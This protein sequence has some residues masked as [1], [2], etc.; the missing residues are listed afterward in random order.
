MTQQ[1]LKS[2]SV[3]LLIFLS[4][5]PVFVQE[6]KSTTA[7]EASNQ[8]MIISGQWFLSY[9]IENENKN[10]NN[11]FRLKRGYVTFRK[12]LNPNLLVRVTQDVTVDREGDGEGD[13]E[14]RLKYGFL[15]YTRDKLSL[16]TRPYI[17]FGVVQ[18]PWIDFEQEIN[19]Y[20]VQ[21][22]MFLERNKIL[23]SADYGLTL[24]AQIGDELKSSN[25]T[26]PGKSG[27]GQFG[28]F[29]LGL[30]NGGGY[31]A[32]EKNANK[33]VQARISLRLLPHTL[34][35]LQLSWTGALGKGNTVAAPNFSANALFFSLEQTHFIFTCMYYSG[36]GNIDGTAVAGNGKSMAPKGFSIF[37]EASLFFPELKLF[38]RLDE[39]KDA[40][41]ELTPDHR[42]YITGIAYKFFKNSRIII[43]YDYL[44]LNNPRKKGETGFELALEF[45]Y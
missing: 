17:D 8:D 35:G 29:A 38:L 33:L 20:R 36:K 41:N 15:R 28:S 9:D 4:A 34:P 11:E 6:K 39:F 7:S 25:S 1:N 27:Q 14:F 3:L 30:Y 12:S 10:I 31:E 37:T 23:K 21:G 19:R 18:C 42:R 26:A 45:S 16:L 22:T 44:Y 32:L 5:A 13:V 40:Q 43:D 2:L 24:G